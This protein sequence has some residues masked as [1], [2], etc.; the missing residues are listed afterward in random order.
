MATKIIVIPNIIG[1]VHR[2]WS[3]LHRDSA[4]NENFS[5]FFFAGNI[6]DDIQRLQVGCSSECKVPNERGQGKA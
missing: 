2:H 6:S 1:V 3:T 4:V 5:I